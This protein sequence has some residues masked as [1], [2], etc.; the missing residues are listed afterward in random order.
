MVAIGI[1][2]THKNVRLKFPNEIALLV[3]RD[4]FNGL[5]NLVISQVVDD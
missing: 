2:D 4:V 5:I 3:W 1:L